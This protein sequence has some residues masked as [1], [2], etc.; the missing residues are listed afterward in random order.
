MFN[1]KCSLGRLLKRFF[2]IKMVQSDL[3]Q[4]STAQ[5]VT[6]VG[7]GIKGLY[8]ARQLNKLGY[9]VTILERKKHA[10]GKIKTV[11]SG[12][13]FTDD[14]NNNESFACPALVEMGPMR[15]LETHRNTLKLLEELELEVIPYIEDN[16]NAPFFI[17][18]KRGKVDELNIGVLIEVGL[19]K[20][21]I[22]E[23]E[24]SLTLATSFTEVLIEAFRNVDEVLNDRHEFIKKKSSISTQI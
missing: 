21:D 8:A 17:N 20:N 23:A 24:S 19:I 12:S 6:I 5:H 10:G 22:L 14:F 13:T 4:I 11:R 18:G 3:L 1:E 15:I 7:A 16:G 2:C 9:Q